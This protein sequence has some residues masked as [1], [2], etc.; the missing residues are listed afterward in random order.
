MNRDRAIMVY[1]KEIAQ[2]HANKSPIELNKLKA[3]SEFK[4]QNEYKGLQEKNLG[5]SPHKIIEHKGKSRVEITLQQLPKEAAETK[6]DQQELI[7][8]NAF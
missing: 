5:L 6:A 3:L 1:S 2:K 8:F 4:H 7:N